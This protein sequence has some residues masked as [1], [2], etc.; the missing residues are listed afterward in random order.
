[1]LKDFWDA[2]LA[3]QKRVAELARPV[4][5]KD[6]VLTSDPDRLWYTSGGELKCEP[7]P[8]VATKLEVADLPSLVQ[9]AIG[10]LD[11]VEAFF[12]VGS[13]G[14]IAHPIFEGI[15]NWREYA[16]LPLR[17]TSEYAFL[18]GLPNLYSQVDLLHVLR[19]DLRDCFEPAGFA[20]S[21]RAIKFRQQTTGHAVI[22]H[23]QESMG[24]SIESEITGADS[25]AEEI[26]VNCTPFLPAGW[27]H[28]TQPI[29]VAVT[30]YVEGQNF[31]LS[32]DKDQLHALLRENQQAIRYSLLNLLGPDSGAIVLLGD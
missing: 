15:P 3:E 11:T 24:R 19:T 29:A 4:L 16:H 5:A 28:V 25:I 14:V 13:K 2:M 32:V 26:V 27:T 9:A 30:V 23:G 6:T 20:G 7:I 12:I 21:I 22:Q 18:C 1:M 31:K 10:L 8:R 17:W